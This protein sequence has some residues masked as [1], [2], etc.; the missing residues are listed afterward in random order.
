MTTA[1]TRNRRHLELAFESSNAI[2]MLEG[3]NA[4]EESKEMQQRIISG[5][6]N[7]EEAIQIVLDRAHSRR[8]E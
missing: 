7:F 3:L 2:L 5:E 8:L 6:L 1:I 4:N